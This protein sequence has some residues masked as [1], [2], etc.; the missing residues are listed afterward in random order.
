MEKACFARICEIAYSA[1]G[2]RIAA[3]KEGMV[4]A[5]LGK[6]IRELG[7][8]SANEYLGFLEQNRESEVVQLLDLLST[9]VTHFF[10][11]SEHFDFVSQTVHDWLAQG[12]KRFRFWSAA[13][14]TGEEPYTLA[15]TLRDTVRSMG[16]PVD[17]KLLATDI[18][19]RVLA[20]AGEGRYP[21][22][23][24]EQIPPP[25][26]RR[27]F[28]PE[29]TGGSKMWSVTDELREMIVFRRL[30]LSTPPFPM[31]GPLDI[32]FCRNVMFYFD[33]PIKEGLVGE[34]H[35]L[36]RPDGYLITGKSESVPALKGL[37]TRVG[38]AVYR[39]VA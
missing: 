26:R 39:K 38:P 17:V 25:L 8:G 6:R 34:I 9:N 4:S 32:V 10:R 2:I 29:K 20:R 11:E 18:S 30:N 19:T 22:D 15:M 3:G 12:Q 13:S 28:R 16:R 31:R 37:F 24:L 27:Y 23:S 21:A 7:F 36:L 35:R 14:S 33:A 5:R 1:S